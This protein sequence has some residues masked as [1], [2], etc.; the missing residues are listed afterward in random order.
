MEPRNTV[1]REE[2]GRRGKLGKLLFSHIPTLQNRT[3]K[4]FPCD[5]KGLKAAGCGFSCPFQKEITCQRSENVDMLASCLI[6]MIP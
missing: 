1:G 3:G 6:V 4:D 2:G 5:V